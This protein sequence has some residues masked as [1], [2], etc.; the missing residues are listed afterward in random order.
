MKNKK[1]LIA[2]MIVILVVGLVSVFAMG[3]QD[4]SWY[5]S[6]DWKKSGNHHYKN[7]GDKT[8][9]LEKMGLPLDATDAQIIEAKKELW[10]QS[11]SDHMID[12]KE[13][14]GLPDDAS[15]EEVHEA[16]LKWKDKFHSKKS[17][18]GSWCGKS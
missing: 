9:W 17:Y 1:I 13:K 2:G 7:F 15:E 10:G 16:M 6:K 4:K 11:K 5:G 18:K 8:S 3:H 14:L 12:I